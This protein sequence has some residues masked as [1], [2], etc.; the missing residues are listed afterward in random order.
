MAYNT[1]HKKQIA[2]HDNGD[3]YVY[4]TKKIREMKTRSRKHDSNL[5]QAGLADYENK[6]F[7]LREEEGETDQFNDPNFPDYEVEELM[8]KYGDTETVDIG[9]DINSYEDSF[10]DYAEY[11]NPQPGD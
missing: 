8:E 7:D 5:I 11:I 2:S 4:P 1:R 9:D 6:E 10:F 3:D